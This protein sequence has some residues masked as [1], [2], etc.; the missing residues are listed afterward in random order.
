MKHLCRRPKFQSFAG[1]I[2]Q[3]AFYCFNFLVV[4][5]F[6]RALLR[7]KL[8][9]QTIKVLLTTS[10]PG[11]KGPSKVAR[12]RQRFINQPMSAELFPVVVDQRLAPYFEGRERLDVRLA[13]QVSH[14]V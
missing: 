7:H 9:Q 1:A 14:V 13:Y 11:R 12:T 6:H 10:L 5:V 3:S 2:I 8:S 4:D